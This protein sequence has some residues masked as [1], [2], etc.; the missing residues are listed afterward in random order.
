MNEPFF[1]THVHFWDHEVNDLRWRFLDADFDHPRLKNTQSLDAPRFGPEE[2][3]AEAGSEE[4][5][6]VVHVHCAQADDLTLETRFLHDLAGV[7]GWPHAVIAAARL[8]ERDAGHQLE[9][10]R[11]YPLVRGVRDLTLQGDIT[12]EDVAT[13][14]DAA[15]ELGLSIELM[16]PPD[17]LSSM[18][19][20]AERWPSITLVVGHTGLPILRDADYL[21]AWE[22]S[23]R[24]VARQTE[25]TVLKIS[26]LASS[27]DPSWTMDSLRPLVTTAIEVFG[28]DRCMFGTNWPIDRLYGTYPRLVA[29]YRALVA[30]L[31]TDERRNVLWGTAAR[32]YGL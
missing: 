24:A 6:K 9:Q 27:A 20:L 2:L 32:T 8:R 31:P 29:A 11:Q 23:L 26:A 10:Q 16:L 30:H 25:N 4:P 7:T 18:V 17:R 3:K 15:S 5:N 22:N 12:P 1:D 14:C 28:S 19:R 13:A 21:T